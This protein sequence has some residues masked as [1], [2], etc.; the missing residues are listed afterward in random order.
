MKTYRNAL[1]VFMLV[2]VRSSLGQIETPVTNYECGGGTASSTFCIETSGWGISRRFLALHHNIEWYLSGGTFTS[3]TWTTQLLAELDFYKGGDDDDAFQDCLDTEDISA[4][5]G[6][7]NS[8]TNV[9]LSL[10]VPPGILSFQT[11]VSNVIST[12]EYWDLTGNVS[13]V[14]GTAAGQAFVSSYVGAASGQWQFEISQQS[15]VV[16][17]TKST[18]PSPATPDSGIYTVRAQSGVSACDEVVYDC[19]PQEEDSTYFV[20]GESDCGGATGDD[21]LYKLTSCEDYDSG[22]NQA[23]G[24][25]TYA[26]IRYTVEP[27]G[28]TPGS[29]VTLVGTVSGNHSGFSWTGFTQP[30]SGGSDWSNDITTIYHCDENCDQ[31]LSADAH[32]TSFMSYGLTGMAFDLGRPTQVRVTRSLVVSLDM[33]PLKQTACKICTFADQVRLKDAIAEGPVEASDPAYD[34]LLDRDLDGDLDEDD[35]AL[36]TTEPSNCCRGDLNGDGQ[37][38]T[39]DLFLFLDLYFAMDL[40]ADFDGN[41]LVEVADLFDFLDVYFAT[42]G[43]CIPQPA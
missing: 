21:N 20:V 19:T 1:L 40:G 34:P 7:P 42:S 35:L 2:L 11:T 43:P 4:S 30:V 15:A 38:D 25:A 9:P 29:A 18:P 13:G 10:E 33:Q 27:S 24:L 16:G 37:V 31:T 22:F 6:G 39:A 32:A 41:G 17:Y 14:G 36:L 28:G 5:R 8:S 3:G 23:L 26:W 12:P